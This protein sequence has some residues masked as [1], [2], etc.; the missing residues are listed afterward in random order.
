MDSWPSGLRQSSTKRPGVKASPEFESLTIRQSSMLESFMTSIPAMNCSISNI[1]DTDLELYCSKHKLHPIRPNSIE[2]FYLV[3]LNS[4][5]FWIH[6]NMGSST[7]RIGLC[8]DNISPELKSRL[9]EGKLS[10]NNILAVV[11]DNFVSFESLYIDFEHE[12]NLFIN[13]F[14]K[15]G[16]KVS[17]SHI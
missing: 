8:W 11:K 7:A 16:V 17:L 3:E 9:I 5:P 6:W 14:K 15:I 13:L 1:S 10:Y 12:F 4:T 2:H